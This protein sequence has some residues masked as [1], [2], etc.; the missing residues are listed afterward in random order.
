MKR[1]KSISIPD[2]INQSASKEFTQIPNEL[3]RNPDLTFKAKGLLSLLLSNKKGWHSYIATIKQMSYEGEDAIRSALKEL[4]QAGYL[5]RLRYRDKKTKVQRGS[6]WAYTDFPGKFN[7]NETLKVLDK[8]G[9]EVIYQGNKKLDYPNEE[10]PDVDYP[11]EENPSLKIL[12]DKNINIKN[13][14]NIYDQENGHNNKTTNSS[15]QS[16][17]TIKERN[18]EYMYLA[19]KLSNIILTQKKIKHT[20]QQL[21]KW[22]DAIRKLSENNG[23]EKSRIETA[24]DWYADNIGGTYI[25][26]I[27]S[28]N[29]LKDKFIK[30]E[31]AMERE[32]KPQKNSSVSIGSGRSGM[33]FPN[34]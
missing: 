31:N 13:N 5:I 4:E 8:Q 16:K 34:K 6:F 3:L 7:F 18:R 30:L 14:N 9:M 25:P 29:S 32:N 15:S 11:N 20:A 22:A 1:K 33:K 17:P 19:R 28:G 2:I 12:N 26:V 27:E 23:V 10:N 24:L 21:R